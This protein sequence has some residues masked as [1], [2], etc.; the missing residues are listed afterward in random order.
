MPSVM[1]LL[2]TR[3]S[4]AR[5]RVEEL[6]VEA[7]RV[8]AE[9]AEAEAVLERRLIAVAELADALAA[10]AQAEEPVGP[11]PVPVVVKQPVAGSAVPSWREGMTVEVLAPDYR[12]L[13]A[14]L[15]AGAGPEGL[16]AKNLAERLGL[17]PLPAKVEGV[18]VK[19]KRLAARG[20]LA[21]D[22]AGLFTPRR[23]AG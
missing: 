18:R 23:T 17:E 9:L 13:L 4:T 6:R 15:E 10:N 7:E 11:V 16:R 12:R 5:V 21:E 2:E 3:E 19:A 14:V 1:G 8:L 20:W 22:R